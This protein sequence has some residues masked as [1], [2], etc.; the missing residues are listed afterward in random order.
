MV[1]IQART[2]LTILQE[3]I[4]YRVE[5]V[6]KRLSFR[7]DKILQRLHILEGLFI[8]FHLEEVI[9]IIREEDHPKAV[10]MERLNL[11]DLQAEAILELKLRHLAKLEEQRILK[12][13]KD[14]SKESAQLKAILDSEKRLKGFAEEINE[15][16]EKY[17]DARCSPLRERAEAQMMKEEDKILSEPVTIILSQK[18][19]VRAAKGT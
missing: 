7:L 15:D 8:V 6:R 11:S 18:G 1:W 4:A 10:L 19:W 2:L 14:L 12:E 9:R 16:V 3:W 17:G 5:T 13:Q